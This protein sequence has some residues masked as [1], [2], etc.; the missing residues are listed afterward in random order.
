M[1]LGRRIDVCAREFIIILLEFYDCGYV[2]CVYDFICC[3][4][5]FF[6][7]NEMFIFKYLVYF[8][9]K[10]NVLKYSNF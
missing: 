5:L 9:F 8:K 4:E 3:W 1:F 7:W 6:L 10:R 2:F